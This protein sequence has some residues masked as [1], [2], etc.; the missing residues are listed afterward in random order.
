MSTI[1]VPDDFEINYHEA[2]QAQRVQAA[3]QRIDPGDVL[4]IIDG[5]IAAEADPRQHP[6]FALVEFY[7][8]RCTA[9]DGGAFFD[10]CKSLV[11]SAIETC[12]DDALAMED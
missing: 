9:V 8:D 6:L 5:R 10:R 1:H 3:L 12:L 7:L 4:A 11:L 2:H